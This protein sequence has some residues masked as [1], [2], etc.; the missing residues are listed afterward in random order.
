MS[1]YVFWILFLLIIECSQFLCKGSGNVSYG[2]RHVINF[3]SWTRSHHLVNH[4]LI[5]CRVSTLLP[6]PYSYK[7]VVR[8]YRN[9]CN[10]WR[11]SDICYIWRVPGQFMLGRRIYHFKM[12][13]LNSIWQPSIQCPF[14]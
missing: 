8:S 13:N 9:K 6:L 10:M 11:L 4:L 12:N 3:C 7:P 1:K 14:S 2:C 5:I